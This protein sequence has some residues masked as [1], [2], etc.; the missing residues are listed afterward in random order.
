MISINGINTKDQKTFSTSSSQKSGVH[1]AFK[2]EDVQKMDKVLIE[3][4]KLSSEHKFLQFYPGWNAENITNLITKVPNDTTSLVA[5]GH[6]ILKIYE[7]TFNETGKTS[8]F[9]LLSGGKYVVMQQDQ[10]DLCVN[11][12]KEELEKHIQMVNLQDLK[13]EISRAFHDPKLTKG[14]SWN[15]HSVG[16]EGIDVNKKENLKTINAAKEQ[17]GYLIAEFE[18]TFKNC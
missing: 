5:V 12:I 8:D 6:P 10:V 3:G 9:Q 14:E 2:G 16:F 4:N 1:I 11:Y 13:F 7:D 17:V 18:I 15:D